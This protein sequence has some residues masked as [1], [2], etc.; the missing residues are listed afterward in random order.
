MR[1]LEDNE[2]EIERERCPLLE[3]S[4]SG[5]SV[6]AHFV[7]NLDELG[8]AGFSKTGAV[9]YLPQRGGQGQVVGKLILGAWWDVGVAR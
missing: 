8:M 6:A 5:R 9:A 4:W 7:L 2:E 3:V 1:L